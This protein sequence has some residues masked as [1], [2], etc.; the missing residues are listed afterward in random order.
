MFTFYNTDPAV[1]PAK[2]NQLYMVN[3]INNVNNSQFN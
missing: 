1:K 3:S 2:V